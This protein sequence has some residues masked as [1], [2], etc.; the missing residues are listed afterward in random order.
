MTLR[1]GLL[2]RPVRQAMH[3]VRSTAGSLK[4]RATPKL[5]RKIYHARHPVGTATTHLRR[6]V[7]RSFF[8]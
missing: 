1:R 8:K 6:A 4:P 2:P 3:P 5:V 7:R